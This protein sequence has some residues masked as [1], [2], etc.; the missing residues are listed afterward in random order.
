MTVST[1]DSEPVR[2]KG[3]SDTE[4][5]SGKTADTYVCIHNY[6]LKFTTVTFYV[7]FFVISGLRT[8][9]T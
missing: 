8:G 5:S 7:N 3:L 2:M 4:G 1:A 9:C 6:L